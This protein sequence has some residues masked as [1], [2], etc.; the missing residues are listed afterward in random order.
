MV[1]LPPPKNNK[2]EKVELSNQLEVLDSSVLAS[3]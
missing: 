2:V 1:T 3:K